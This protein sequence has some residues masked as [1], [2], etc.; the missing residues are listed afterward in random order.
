VDLDARTGQLAE[1]RRSVAL[2]V[3]GVKLVEAF[4][5]KFVLVAVHAIAGRNVSRLS[6]TAVADDSPD[7]SAILAT[8]QATDRW[9]RGQAE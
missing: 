2:T 9:V 7:R 3:D 1:G 4:D 6:G 5:R 8:L